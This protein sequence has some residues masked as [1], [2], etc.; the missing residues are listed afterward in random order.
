MEAYINAIIMERRETGERRVAHSC[1]CGEK[2]NQI[3]ALDTKR[4]LLLQYV[5]K[6]MPRAVLETRDNVD[7][8]ALVSGKSEHP[9]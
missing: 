1:L 3:S 5:L 4:T 8:G 6:R 9:L 7:P 2:K